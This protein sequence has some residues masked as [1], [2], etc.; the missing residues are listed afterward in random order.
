MKE[1]L[2]RIVTVA[3]LTL[4]LL[5]AVALSSRRVAVPAAP[6]LGI[7]APTAALATTRTDHPVNV[8]ADT[9]QPYL[10]RAASGLPER[11]YV[12][13]T[14]DGTVDVID[15]AARA[16]VGHFAVG[17]VP[18]HITPAWDMR[19]LYVNNTVSNTLTV[20]DPRAGGPVDTLRVHDPYNLYFTLDGT[21]AVVV[22]ERDQRLDLYTLP[23]WTAA[24]SVAVPWAG[25]DHLDFSAD[26]RTLLASAEYSGTVVKV[27]VGGKTVT[28]SVDVGGLPVDVRLAPD[29]TVFYVANQGRHGVSVIDPARMEEIQFIPTGRGAHGLQISRDARALYVS[30]RLAGTISVI[31]LA[32]RQVVATWDVGGSPDMMQV[33][34]DGRELWVTNRFA[35]S[36]SVIDTATGRV[37]DRVEVGASPHGLAYFPQPGRFSLGH[38]GVY[39]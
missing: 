10:R 9:M 39:R 2:G 31:D 12:P 29:G 30:N 25:V 13:N 37:L 11:V 15:P 33:S 18:H 4:A 19:A 23:A 28:G 27:D 35:S 7:P 14:Q 8:Y 16:V 38:N 36:V 26:G 17:A 3:G 1:W 22:A 21:T 6:G 24:G 20:I 5:A 34:P 32:T